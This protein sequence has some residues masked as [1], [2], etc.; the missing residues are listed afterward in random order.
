MSEVKPE[1]FVMLASEVQYVDEANELDLWRQH[2]ERINKS[3]SAAI[4]NCG[5]KFEI[6]R[7]LQ[8]KAVVYFKIKNSEQQGN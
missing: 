5:T 6:E 7:L 8:E 1:S 4:S 3:I 2:L